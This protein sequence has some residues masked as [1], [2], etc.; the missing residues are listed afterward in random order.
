NEAIKWMWS[1]GDY[2]RIARRLMPC[3]ERLAGAAGVA[4]GMA[5][6]DVAAG[7]GNFAV[8]AARRGAAVI[9]TDLTPHM[10]GLGQRRSTAEGLAIE[11]RE[12]DAEQLPFESERFDLV[13]SVFGAM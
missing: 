3:A 4:P 6:L 9:A 7:N 11:W 10:V 5:A 13:A 1:L 2:D 12:A 8:A